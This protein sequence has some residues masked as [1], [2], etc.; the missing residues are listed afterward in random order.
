MHKYQPRVRLVRKMA[1]DVM[2][3]E[4]HHEAEEYKTFIFPE[5]IF[6]AVTAYQNQLVSSD[7]KKSASSGL[8]HCSPL[9]RLSKFCVPWILWSFAL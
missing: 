1:A 8:E 4:P 2:N 6:I 3:G 7:I 9:R 5:T